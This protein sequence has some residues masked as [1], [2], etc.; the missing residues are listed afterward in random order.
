MWPGRVCVIHP[1]VCC[2]MTR[3]DRVLMEVCVVVSVPRQCSESEFACTSGR[4]IAGRW[5]C[6]GDHDC[7]DGSDE[8]RLR[9]TEC[10]KT[11]CSRPSETLIAVLCVSCSTAVMWSVITTSFSVRTATASRS[12]GGVTLMP[13][14]WTAVTR[15]TVTL[16][17]K[18]TLENMIKI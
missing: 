1:T 8:V 7:A 2:N 10:R 6:D 9:T 16:E 12:A 3:H 13:T 11:H 18:H 15:S 17:V 4:C 5:K 14:A